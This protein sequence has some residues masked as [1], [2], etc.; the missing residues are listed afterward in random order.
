M[1]SKTGHDL[2]GAGF[3]F[4]QDRAGN[5]QNCPSVGWISSELISATSE[6]VVILVEVVVVAAERRDSVSAF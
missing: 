5:G 3:R 1:E 2:G 6:T 4:L